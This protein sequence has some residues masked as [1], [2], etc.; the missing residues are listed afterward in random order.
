MPNLITQIKNW[1]KA[2]PLYNSG[3]TSNNTG[4]PGFSSLAPRDLDY[5]RTDATASSIVMQCLNWITRNFPQGRFEV[6]DYQGDEK[7]PIEG[8]ELTKL[9]AKPNPWYSSRILWAGT[10]LDYNVDGNAYW[11][12]N[13]PSVG[14]PPQELWYLPS[15]SVRPYW[16]IDRD[17]VFISYYVYTN[18]RGE[19]IRIEV[20]DIV[21]IRHNIDPREHRMGISPLKAVLLEVFTDIEAGRF[22]AAL[23][24]NMGIPGVL[25]TPGE[26]VT[27]DREKAEQFKQ[28]W[29][30]KFA[31][32]NRGKTAF[33]NYQA[34]VEQLGFNPTELSLKDVRRIPEERISGALGIPAIVAG[35]GAGLERS[36]YSN[37]EQARTQAFEENLV[38][39]WY[40]MADEI[41]QQLL[42]DF[43]SSDTRMAHFE[44]G[45][46][47]ALQESETD[48]QSR[49]RANFAAGGMTL[50]EFRQAINLEPIPTGDVIF[51]PGHYSV[52][53][54]AEPLVEV[55]SG[56]QNTPVDGQLPG[57]TN[58]AVN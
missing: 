56:E 49:A 45:H 13:R 38:P 44:T 11:L 15:F 26:N 30:Q 37:T 22:S 31:G 4:W 8:H 57:L 55:P 18:P 16:P 20:D 42:P 27:L 28:Q 58:G 34:K 10:L 3:W 2:D 14:A 51:I 21:H 7:T 48:A 32:D 25:V 33:L 6:V 12:K 35:L 46:I 17:D 43:E 5:T 1:L 41:T 29:E 39:T 24:K 53:D 36:T 19:Q 23:L 40:A 54:E 47:K 9:L 50:N 52:R